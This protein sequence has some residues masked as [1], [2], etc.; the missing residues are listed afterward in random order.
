MTDWCSGNFFDDDIVVDQNYP[1]M[2]VESP[3]EVKC[4][5]VD[6]V[7]QWQKVT[8]DSIGG[9]DSIWEAS[10]APRWVSENEIEVEMYGRRFLM[11]AK[12]LSFRKMLEQKFEK[13]ELKE[14][15]VKQGV[16]KDEADQLV[17]LKPIESTG[18][19]VLV[20]D[21]RTHD[22][23]YKVATQ[24]LFMVGDGDNQCELFEFS[25]DQKRIAFVSD[26]GFNVFEVSSGTT[27]TLHGS[28]A[29][30]L[31]GKLD[32]VYQEELYGRGNFKGYWWS[33]DSEH[34]AL[35]NLDETEV[36]KFTITDHIP[37]RGSDEFLSY[38]KAGDPNPKVQ[39]GIATA[40]SL[41]DVNWVAMPDRDDQILISNVGWRPDGAAC[42]FQVQN[43]AQTY[44]DLM[45]TE[46]DGNAKTIF[47][48][49]TEAWIESPGNPNWL[50]DGGFVWLS[51]RNGYRHLYHYD[52]NGEL[53]KQLTNGNWEVRSILAFDSQDQVV[54]FSAAKENA[55]E[56]HAYRLELESGNLSRITSGSGTHRVNFNKSA[57]HFI[58]TASTSVTLPE[59][60]LYASDGTFLEELANAFG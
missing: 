40:G 51:P 45:V 7:K 34:I 24:E 48:D 16:G 41:S 44:L 31:I 12:S 60:K 35:L 2:R 46:P 27:Q 38:P 18:R 11:D 23:I 59:H 50:P 10:A 14:L 33:P 20:F 43:R 56:M 57:T 58:D 36:E 5:V 13:T 42:V 28:D 29:N 15:L 4:S 9:K 54:F 8:L 32:W 25:P 39:I 30:D 49:Q 53:V 55:F 19:E 47:R 17:E 6:K 3:I 26:A 22:F 21:G 1:V 37:V 52:A